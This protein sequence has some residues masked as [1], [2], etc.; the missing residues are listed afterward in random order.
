M[1]LDQRHESLGEL[2]RGKEIVVFNQ[3]AVLFYMQW[4]VADEHEGVCSI[5][6]AEQSS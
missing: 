3:Q 5:P 1:R 2:V 6:G 4:G